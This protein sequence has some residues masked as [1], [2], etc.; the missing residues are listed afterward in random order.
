MNE[1]IFGEISRM[2]RSVGASSPSPGLY[3]RSSWMHYAGCAWKNQQRGTYDLN[4]A[5]GQ[6]IQIDEIAVN[7]RG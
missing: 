5:T 6:G 2:S 1:F 3:G 7:T 4:N